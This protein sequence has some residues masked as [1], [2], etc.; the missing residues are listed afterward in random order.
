MKKIIWILCIFCILC[1]FQVFSYT[2]PDQNSVNLTLKT[3]YTAP[4]QL[5]VNLTLGE[6]EAVLPVGGNCSCPGLNNNWEVN[7]VDSCNLGDC[8]LGTGRLNFTG[9]GETSCTGNINTTDLG[10]P[11]SGNT[12][13]INDSNCIIK[14]R[15]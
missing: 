1:I 9:S 7:H 8:E 14:V 3:P 5:E 2:A 11:G 15:S 10:D 12:L 13:W 6:I 4:D